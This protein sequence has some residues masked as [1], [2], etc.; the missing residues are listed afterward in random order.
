MSRLEL[1]LYILIGS[2]VAIYVIISIIKIVKKKK[3]PQLKDKN[4]DDDK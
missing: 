2:G 3:H 4:E 1:I